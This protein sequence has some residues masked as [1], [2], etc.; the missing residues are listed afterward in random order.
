MGG[1]KHLSDYADKL[2]DW[3]EMLRLIKPA[4]FI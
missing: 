4:W 2:P 3:H 1:G